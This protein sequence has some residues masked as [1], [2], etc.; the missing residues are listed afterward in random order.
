MTPPTPQAQAAQL[1]KSIEGLAHQKHSCDE[2]GCGYT[3]QAIEVISDALSAVAQAAREEAVKTIRCERP[4]DIIVVDHPDTL[5]GLMSIKS[6]CHPHHIVIGEV[7]FVESAFTAGAT[8]Q[9][10]AEHQKL[11]TIAERFKKA[12]AWWKRW[13]EDHLN[14]ASPANEEGFCPACGVPHEECVYQAAYDM[15]EALRALRQPPAGPP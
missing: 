7:K 9:R 10:E 15:M 14:I 5:D 11:L 4:D 1:V 6:P 2:G 12:D 8:A 3:T 13:A